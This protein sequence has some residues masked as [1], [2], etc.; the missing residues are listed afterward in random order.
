MLGKMVGGSPLLWQERK[1]GR[2]PTLL[3]VLFLGR[4]SQTFLSTTWSIFTIENKFE[5]IF[6]EALLLESFFTNSYEMSK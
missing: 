2:E 3:D 4:M 6:Q 1:Q 5:S